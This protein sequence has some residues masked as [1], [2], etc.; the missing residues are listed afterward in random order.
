LGLAKPS[1]QKLFSDFMVDGIKCGPDGARCDIDG[2][3]R[4]RLPDLLERGAPAEAEAAIAV[5]VLGLTAG[6]RGTMNHARL[7]QDW[8]ADVR[9]LHV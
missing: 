7:V 5:I 1:N 3:V 2:N 4:W 8:L 6:R 9:A